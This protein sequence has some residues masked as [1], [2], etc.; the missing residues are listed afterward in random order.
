MLRFLYLLVLSTCKKSSCYFVPF[1]SDYFH[2][3]KYSHL[4]RYVAFVRK[5]G[6]KK[7]TSFVYSKR[8]SDGYV[9]VDTSWYWG[10]FH[11]LLLH[12]LLRIL[13]WKQSHL[14]GIHQPPKDHPQR[15]IQTAIMNPYLFSTWK[16]TVPFTSL[17][18]RIFENENIIP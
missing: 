7:K 6:W 3:G 4:H 14:M 11:L 12:L 5:V 17:F 18:R 10:Q 15:T 2:T 13:L 16:G 9:T 8:E 1:P